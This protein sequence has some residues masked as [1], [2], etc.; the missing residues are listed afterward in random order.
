MK[1]T[2]FCEK[3]FK[4]FFYYFEPHLSKVGLKKALV[5]K[6]NAEIPERKFVELFELAGEAEHTF[7]GLKIGSQLQAEHIGALGHAVINAQNVEQGIE[8][9]VNYV[10]TYSHLSEIKC[11][12]EKNTVE[13]SYQISD[14]S[15]SNKHQ[16]AEF[17]IA[18]IHRLLSLC[19]DQEISLSAI[20]FEHNQPCN[21][22]I[23]KE[24]FNC[25]IHFQASAS[26]LTFSRDVLSYCSDKRDS[27]LFDIL[28]EHLEDVRKKRNTTELHN[29]ISSLI[30]SQ[31]SGGNLS[32]DHMS[33][34]LGVS[35][36]TL[37]RRL[38]DNKL[39]YSHI[40]NELKHQLSINHLKDPSLTL[41][42]ISFKLGYKE[43]SSFSR[44]FKR[45]T[46]I[47]PKKY[48]QSLKYL[49]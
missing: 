12:V 25:P 48:R 13:I 16:D 46:G 24:I 18:G 47:S 23:Y 20:Y 32:I 4:E 6:S 15:I 42:D 36:R 37:Q 22:D 35:V 3:L 5:Q 9:L 44:A 8:T 26:K 2:I 38:D 41:S 11:H 31:L 49:Q 28:V 34:L 14:P 39:D 7:V 10:I 33:K 1:K 21:T 30:A 45:W 29:Q 40:L 19:A 17:A 27:R 43:S